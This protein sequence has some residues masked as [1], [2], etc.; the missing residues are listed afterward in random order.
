MHQ[1]TLLYTVVGCCLF[2]QNLIS[3]LVWFGLV[4]FVCLC[5]SYKHAY[6]PFIIQ[7]SFFFFPH[8]ILLSFF[9]LYYGYVSTRL[10]STRSPRPLSSH[11]SLSFSLLIKNQLN[12]YSSH[13]FSTKFF[14]IYYV[15]ST[16]ILRVIHSFHHHHLHQH[17]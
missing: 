6:M 16:I 3:V 8:S 17:H 15:V 9:I 12:F 7:S 14:V 5:L 1:I 13:L 2:Y 11:N 10:D 4:F